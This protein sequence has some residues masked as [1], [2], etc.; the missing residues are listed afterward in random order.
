MKPDFE[1]VVEENTPWIL[2]YIRT[3]TESRETA[4]DLTQEVWLR[5]FRAWG[6]YNEQGKLRRW[7]MRIAQNV[8]RSYFSET[9]EFIV[10]S[11]DSAEDGDDPLL[12]YLTNDAA[13]DP[14]E[15]YE[16]KELVREIL[17]AIDKLPEKHRTVMTFR[18]FDGLTVSEVAARMNIPE[19]SVKSST[20]YAIEK[21]RRE[22]GISSKGE[23][24]MNCEEAKKYL[25]MYAKGKLTPERRKEVGEH[26]AACPHCREMEEALEKL[27]PHIPASDEKGMYYCG[28]FFPDEELIYTCIG[29]NAENADEMNRK[30]KEWGGVIPDDEEWFSSGQNS[31]K[32]LAC[33]L[34]EGEECGFVEWLK[35]AENEYYRTKITKMPRVYPY[36]YTYDVLGNCKDT[37]GEK[38][39]WF[40]CDAFCA[41]YQAVPKEHGE[42]KM[43]SGN[44]FIE[45]GAYTFAY[46]AR[47]TDAEEPLFVR[48]TYE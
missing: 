4:E 17:S 23:N 27:M 22:I 32:T 36:M 24:K 3:K 47:Y 44:G 14:V 38:E 1:A 12:S 19:G 31:V 25:F 9:P 20:H 45:C 21:I 34:N 7:L 42:L 40:G 2:H 43:K 30:L 18:Y 8:V 15:L 26:L 48:Y 28:I 13:D 29:R 41:L 16:H 39:N 35:D 46:A 10:Y 5:A 6:S 33:F 37:Y 11:L